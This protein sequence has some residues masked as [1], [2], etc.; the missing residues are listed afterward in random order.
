LGE[1]ATGVKKCRR[2]RQGIN[3]RDASDAEFIDPN[4]SINGGLV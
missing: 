4:R 3:R 2:G 1:V